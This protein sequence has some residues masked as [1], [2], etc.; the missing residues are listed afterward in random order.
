MFR[1]KNNLFSQ[2]DDVGGNIFH[3]LIVCQSHRHRTHG[4]PVDVFR[5]CSPDS[6]FEILQLANDIPILEADQVW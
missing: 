4:L 6:G 3:C 1:P 5:M 2:T